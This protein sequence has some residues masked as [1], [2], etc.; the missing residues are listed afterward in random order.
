[1]E[2]SPCK[3]SSHKNCSKFPKDK[4]PSNMFLK[5]PNNSTSQR[6][7][8]CSDCRKATT[9]ARK[10]KQKE[11]D[12]KKKVAEALDPTFRFCSFASHITASK[13]PR[14]KVPV[15]LFLKVPNDP[16]KG[17]Y[18]KCEN[19]RTHVSKIRNNLVERAK[20][21]EEVDPNFG[22]CSSQSH[23]QVSKYPQN[24]VPIEN[25]LKNPQD[26]KSKV[27]KN[28]LECRNYKCEEVKSLHAERKELAVIA[29]KNKSDFLYCASASHT[30]KDVSQ[31]PRD[32][33]PFSMFQRYEDD[34]EDL[35]E[36]CSDCRNHKAVQNNEYEKIKR[37]AAKEDE[38]YCDGCKNYKSLKDRAPNKDGTPSTR[39]FDCKIKTSERW[40]SMRTI[41]YKIIYEM[42]LK[43]GSSCQRCLSIYLIPEEGTEFSVRLESY[44]IDGKLFVDYK[45][46]T[47]LTLDFL[48]K[49][50]DL[51]EF[52]VIELDHLSE[53]E[54]RERGMLQANQKYEPKLG[55]VSTFRS[56]REMRREGKKCQNDC[57]MCHI[58]DT[59]SRESGNYKRPDP[60][61]I[62]KEYVDNLKK[63][64]GCGVCG[65]KTN[66]LFRFL[67]FDHLDPKNKIAAIAEMVK[68]N[69]YNLEDIIEEIK[70][71]RIIC[72]H[73]HKIH[74]HKQLHIFNDVVPEYN[75]NFQ[76]ISWDYKN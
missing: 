9:E 52:R 31:Y 6:F 22:S 29:K 41:Y 47:Y 64:C 49:F 76:I 26:P 4:V 8:N 48:V 35:H 39:C 34:L 19:C 14:D 67:E 56:E 45:G 24:K 16:S 60:E 59:I 2:V 43:T 61:I 20:I 69:N 50:R 25:F 65:Y 28:C 15:E 75:D 27:C 74:T 12:D 53:Q 55:N 11:L 7:V 3:G 68:S 10:K 33:V 42:F 58:E 46:Q 37:L 72:R 71:C 44:Y 32:K 57:C 23:P 13:F 51:L 62:K 17:E 63:E 54:Q 70:K 38:F 5:D 73:C 36:T 66:D 40:L 18:K 30:L 1:M 21:P